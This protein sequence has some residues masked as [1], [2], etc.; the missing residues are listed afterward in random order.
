MTQRAVLAQSVGGLGLRAV[1]GPIAD[2][3]VFI[4]ATGQGVRLANAHLLSFAVATLLNYFLIVRGA[5]AAAGRSADW[6]LHVHLLVVSL[7]AASLRGAVLG[8]LTNVWGWP[9]QAAIVL[10]A[11]AA[12]SL[13][14]PGYALAV[15]TTTWTLGGGEQWRLV[16]IYL[17]VVGFLL[18]LVYITQIELL[19][20]DSYYW[21]YAQH[22]DLGY[23]DH[24]PMVAWL[25]WLGTAVFGDS[26][27][28]VRIG[29][30][31]CAAVASLFAYRLT[32]NLFGEP[33][34]IVALVL[35]QV[36][37][38]FF[39]AGMLMTP[40][41]PL[42]AAWAAA[43]YFLERAL[44]AGRSRAWLLAGLSLGLGLISKY[45]IGMLVPAMLLFVILDRQ[46]RRW[47]LRWE[48]YA[49]L[50]IAGAIFSPVILWNAQHEWASFAFQTS[51]RLAEA[52]RFALHKLII[53][54][55]VLLTPT[56]LLTLL[57]S[58]LTRGAAAPYETEAADAP[59]RWLFIRLTVLVPLS[60]F[61]VFS[62]RHDVK[63]DWTGAPW[64]GAV[65]ALATSIVWFGTKGVRGFRAWLYSA[66]GPTA[67]FMLL[68]Y[69]A[70]LHYLALGLPGVGYS[71]RLELVPVGWRDLG[72]QI[73][74]IAA[75]IRRET[76]LEPVIVGM[77]RYELASQLTFYA[78]DHAR[79]VKE[80]SSR[81]LFGQSGLMYE[82]W[83]SSLA[84]GE[85]PLLLVAWDPHDLSDELTAPYVATLGP[86]R[87]GVL[88]R[89]GV[90]IRN[91]HYRIARGLAAHPAPETSGERQSH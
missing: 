32:R 60:V 87:E 28:G 71:S 63:I 62:L 91:F 4:A 89:G 39:L 8:L 69:S 56:G 88:A 65:P 76:G 14:L 58:R 23:L 57:V 5:A 15:R 44:I 45:T 34:A 84:V 27:L 79:S 2:V 31:C 16:A 85:R 29:A 20:E 33:S 49:A 53:S 17:V 67:V 81:N 61:V 80:T 90:E 75:D 21:N 47:L 55:L 12:M 48:P 50:I 86:P 37:P 40:D 77:D 83:A 72:G 52:P 36:L 66:W 26:E 22:L 46:S 54:V 78:P 19:P 24:P 3:V 10:A 43:L 51:R 74:V 7:F 9:P 38:F 11:I 82:R 41:A 1:W 73:N 25:I 64:L 59:R 70:G 42:T 18:R 68:L 30:L 6:R 35:M 13:A